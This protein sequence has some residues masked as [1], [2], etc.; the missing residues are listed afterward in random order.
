MRAKAPARCVAQQN[1][2][3]VCVGRSKPKGAV[4]GGGGGR[5][6]YPWACP[7]K[8]VWGGGWGGTA[9]QLQWQCGAGVCPSCCPQEGRRECRAG[10]SSQQ[11]RIMLTTSVRPRDRTHPSHPSMPDE[12]RSL[13]VQMNNNSSGTGTQPARAGCPP[14]AGLWATQPVG[15]NGR[16]T[17]NPKPGWGGVWAC[18]ALQVNVLKCGK[19]GGE[20]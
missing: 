7:T 20:M 4:L 9:Q 19:G 5:V 17:S 3:G 1:G 10:R 6:F 18:G 11:A 16:T 14:V 15:H 13:G 12:N 2:R 8:Q